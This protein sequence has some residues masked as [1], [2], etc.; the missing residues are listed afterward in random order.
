[1]QKRQPTEEERR[2]RAEAAALVELS[3]TQKRQAKA[4]PVIASVSSY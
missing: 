1:L 2:F 4:A 3:L